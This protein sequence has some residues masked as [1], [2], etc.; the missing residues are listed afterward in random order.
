[1]TDLVRV[2]ITHGDYNG[3]GYEVIVKSLADDE[4]TELY[5]PVVF[6]FPELMKKAA[7]LL[8]IENLHFNIVRD[9]A[10]AE[11][12][13]INIVDISEGNVDLNPGKIDSNAGRYA[14]KALETASMALKNGEIDVLVTAPIS[15]EGIQGKEFQF[16]GHTEYLEER[17]GDGNKAMMILFSNSLRVALL[18]IHVPLSKVVEEVTKEAV[19]DAAIRF[20]ASLKKDFGIVRPCLAVLSLNPHSGD[21]GVIGTEEEQIIKPALEELREEG[22]LAFGPYPSDGFFGHGS[23]TGFDGILA[24]Y[25]DQGLTPFKTLAA[26]GGVNFTAGLP[27]VRTSPDHGTA[28]DIAWQGKADPSS[29]QEAIYSAIDIFR[30]RKT[31]EE[32]SAN[33][34]K[35]HVNERPD[36]G[37]RQDKQLK[38]TPAAEE[39][40]D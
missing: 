27:V 31:Y 26:N 34:L 18:T 1:M 30:R 6:G 5:T 8:K 39:Q 36:R 37:E 14:V 4:V 38:K 17:V 35:K 22:I 28:Y 19:K 20:S 32:V 24:M 40:N 16:P 3:V 12:G 33:P 7:E 9:A 23:Y 29:M 10:S 21:G 13:K 11:A 2:G 25:H 15:K